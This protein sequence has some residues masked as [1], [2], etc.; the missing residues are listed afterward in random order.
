LTTRE[1]V[2]NQNEVAVTYKNL[3]QDVKTGDK[4]L[5]DDGLIEL[6]VTKIFETDIVC[7]VMNGGQVKTK[8]A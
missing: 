8:K 4:V 7:R 6:L 5:I 1:I 3:P 2:G